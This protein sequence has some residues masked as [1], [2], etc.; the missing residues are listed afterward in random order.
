M[1]MHR[2]YRLAAYAVAVSALLL[3]AS[4]AAVVA[5]GS[6]GNAPSES[7]PSE[8]ESNETTGSITVTNSTAFEV[9]TVSNDSG[10]VT[11]DQGD[12]TC[13]GGF[14][15]DTPNR[16]RTDIQ[17]RGV[18]VTLVEQ[19]S[20]EPFDEIGREQF[21]SLVW[22]E[23]SGYAGLGAYDHIEVQVNQ[24]YETV[25][26]D[27]PLDTVGIHA[28]PVDNCLPAVEGEVAL[29]SQSVAVRS[30]HSE[31]EGLNL[32]ITDTIGVLN[33]SERDSIDRLIESN[34]R[35]SYAIQT[36]FDDPDT[37]DATVVEA[38]DDSQVKL[39]LTRPGGGRTV[40][41]RIDLESE[42]VERTWTRV[43]VERIDGTDSLT[44]G[45]HGENETTSFEVNY[46]EAAS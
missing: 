30:S 5:D 26:R 39:E 29:N 33:E 21:A 15:I 18:T 6:A 45:N 28:R 46:T 42:T 13:G 34:E 2:D 31:L 10:T 44:V 23:I 25:A 12:Q 27:E 8:T 9:T 22:K 24:Y 3:T 14:R 36:E 20:G 37:L 4:G 41:V 1:Q 16:T 35:T 11:F 7:S 19:H 32:N 17:V 43:A 40:V 38:T